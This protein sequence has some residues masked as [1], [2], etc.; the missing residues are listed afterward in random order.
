MPVLHKKQNHNCLV[1][2]NMNHRESYVVS[3]APTLPG[4]HIKMNP[5]K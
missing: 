5:N 3:L 1:Y 2:F 4:S